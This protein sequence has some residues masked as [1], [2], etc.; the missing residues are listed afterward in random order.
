MFSCSLLFISLIKPEKYA[1]R[2]SHK[3]NTHIS[4]ITDLEANGGQ[5]DASG[6]GGGGGICGNNIGGG[7]K[8]G[9]QHAQ[10]GMPHNY[11]DRDSRH[12]QVKTYTDQGNGYNQRSGST[13]LYS[14]VG[15]SHYCWKDRNVL[16][17]FFLL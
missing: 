5:G 6:V 16:Y 1:A 10:H 11:Y 8:P 13:T 12:T 17:S 9:Q 4:T 3:E 15:K 7:G 2:R 14:K